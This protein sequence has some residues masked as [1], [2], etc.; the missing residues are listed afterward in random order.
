MIKWSQKRH[1]AALICHHTYG[2]LRALQL[3]SRQSLEEEFCELR[4]LGILGSFAGPA[5]PR[6]QGSDFSFTL[7]FR[8]ARTKEGGGSNEKVF[9]AAQDAEGC[10]Y[11]GCIRRGRQPHSLLWRLLVQDADHPD[12]LLTTTFAKRAH[13]YEA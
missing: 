10:G 7:L 5:S 6:K 12:T 2:C 4:L 3:F 8:A 13:Y 11:G 9:G 1:F